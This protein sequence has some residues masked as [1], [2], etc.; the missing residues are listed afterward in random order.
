MLQ[1]A[2]DKLMQHAKHQQRVFN[3][4]EM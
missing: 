2:E 1:Q 4:D 3:W